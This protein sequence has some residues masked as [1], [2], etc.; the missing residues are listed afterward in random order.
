VR[1]VG[2]WMQSRNHPLVFVMHAT[3]LHGFTWR[4]IAKG[5][6]QGGAPVQ[7]T[8]ERAIRLR[9]REQVQLG[10]DHPMTVPLFLLAARANDLWPP[11][12]N[13]TRR[14]LVASHALENQV[15]DQIHPEVS[16][17]IAR[18]VI[19]SR[20]RRGSRRQGLR[21]TRAGPLAKKAKVAKAIVKAMAAAG[22][23]GTG[24]SG[25]ERKS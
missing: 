17:P 4:R 15:H 2:C 6:A 14:C 9:F 13:E 11:F 7:G 20:M 18:A 3:A 22:G 25:P 10:A 23:R 5:H 8:P 21:A 16:T 12:R 1:T 24:P 19:Q